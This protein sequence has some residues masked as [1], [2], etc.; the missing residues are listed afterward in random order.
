MNR[1]DFFKA[2]GLGAAAGALTLPR[3][4]RAAAKSAPES[5]HG[6]VPNA[7]RPNF[8][9]ILT[10][11][12]GWGDAAFAGHPYV[13]TPNLDRLAAEST[14]IRQFYVANPVCSPTRCSF[15]TGQYPARF[16]I[17]GHFASPAQN[18]ARD[19]PNRLEPSVP[20]VA[21]I[22]KGAGYATGHFG[23]WH[24]GMT[25]VN[26]YGFDDSATM[27]SGK[28][29]NR[30]L[31]GEEEQ[32]KPHFWGRS[33]RMIVD[34]T[35]GFIRKNEGRS[36]YVNVWTLLPHARLDPTPE[37]LAVYQDAVFDPDHPSWG[38]WM[39]EYFKQA[40]DPQ[41]QMRVFLASLTDLD[42]Q[43]GRLLKFLDD[44]GLADNTVVV[45][46]SDNGPEDYHVANAAN[47]GVGSPGP[48]RARKRS[49]Y[50]GG[51]R[52]F[53]L[54]RWPG[55]VPAGRR[56]EE[57]VVGSVDFLPTVCS[58]AGVSLPDTVKPDGEDV[59][60]IWMG[61]S[62]PRR[63]PLFWEWLFNVAGNKEYAPPP[64]AVRDGNWKL[65]FNPTGDRVEL[66][67]IPRDSAEKRNVATDHPDVVARLRKLG[68]EW[69]AT[70]PAA[71]P[72][73]V[74]TTKKPASNE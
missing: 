69:Q 11:D 13:K 28:E 38:E 39:R 49:L 34:E 68:L 72:R 41:Q 14:W 35:I 1:R 58:L 66:Y 21:S 67:D 43:V 31:A 36:F 24:L 48:L 12:Q 42:E 51:I 65:L 3:W 26:E 45:F 4:L 30:P 2:T 60:D 53:S 59:S 46:A 50:E 23:K 17:H 57:S 15:M 16:R 29:G 19:M 25:P 7:S 56:D 27:V 47:A 22:L 73:N 71:K 8:L 33:T 62:R 64:L 74:S 61:K 6:G 18:A 9:F 40:Q 5:Q 44:E 37:Q 32:S 55:R 70:L 20:N 52:T 10:D 54:V 63:R